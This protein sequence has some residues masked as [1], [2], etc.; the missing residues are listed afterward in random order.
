M[1]NTTPNAASSEHYHSLEYTHIIEG[2]ISL[3]F[4]GLLGAVLYFCYKRKLTQNFFGQR[5]SKKNGDSS[6]R[7]EI[8]LRQFQFEELDKATENFSQQCL[9]G[10]G[11]FGNVYKGTFGEEGT[12]AIKRAHAD[13]YQ[14]VQEFRNE[15]E[16]LSR[17]KHRNLVGLVG[18]CEEDGGRGSKILVYEYVPNGSLLEYILGKRG[19]T[20]TW[21]QRVNIAIGAAKANY[22]ITEWARPSIERGNVDEI[23][24][25]NL[26][27]EPCNMEMMLKMAKLGLRCA[28]KVP[29]QRP[30]M[31][32]VWKELEEALY[33]SDNFINNQPS[34]GSRRSI[35][36]AHCRSVDYDTSQSSMSIDGIG[37][38]RF[39]VEMD[40]LSFQSTSLRCLE[41][42]SV[43]IDIDKSNLRG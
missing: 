26:L 35:V 2:V 21:R 22:H 27:S 34:R 5:T 25:V 8:R 9:L 7:E 41:T 36:N 20:L 17:V 12:Q 15:V 14:S 10:S 23:L 6:F 42:C 1:A 31:T 19:L 40:S 24:D 13:S 39:H 33:E 11:A 16:L 30:T 37:L 28:V 4:I 32:Q 29:K 18:Y 3:A 38:Q 43:S